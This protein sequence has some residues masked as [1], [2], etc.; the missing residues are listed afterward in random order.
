MGEL[1]RLSLGFYLTSSFKKDVSKSD[2]FTMR[3]YLGVVLGCVGRA[4]PFSAVQ[5]GPAGG[6]WMEVVFAQAGRV[7]RGG[8]H[9]GGGQRRWKVVARLFVHME[10][11]LV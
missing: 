2:I 11:V 3:R 4:T 8:E 6:I 10:V 9:V 5:V 1:I 7:V